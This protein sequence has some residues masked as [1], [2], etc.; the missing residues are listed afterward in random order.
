MARPVGCGAWSGSGMSLEGF[1]WE[2]DQHTLYCYFFIYF[3]LNHVACGIVVPQ[4]ETETTLPEVA[5]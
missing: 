1:R 3:W 2:G 5:M 4:S